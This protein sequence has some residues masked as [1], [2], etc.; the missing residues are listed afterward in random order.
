MV[1]NALLRWE[2]SVMGEVVSAQGAG[3][4]NSAVHLKLL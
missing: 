1:T 4:F 2:V 3:A